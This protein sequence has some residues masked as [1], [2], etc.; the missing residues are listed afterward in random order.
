M[1]TRL[2]LEALE[3]RLSPA[4]ILPSWNPVAVAETPT[5]QT[6][7]LLSASDGE[8]RVLL[9]DPPAFLSAPPIQALYAQAISESVGPDGATHALLFDAP[10]GRVIVD[11]LDAAGNYVG[12]FVYRAPN[13]WVPVNIVAGSEDNA[14]RLLWSDTKGTAAIWTLD[15]TGTVARAT[16]AGPFAGWAP[17]KLVA[18]PA[19]QFLL[20]W[21]GPGL[22]VAYWQLNLQTNYVHSDVFGPGDGWAFQDAS[23]DS[24]G[25]AFILWNNSVTGQ[26]A[27]WELGSNGAPTAAA[28]W[29][30]DNSW[31]VLGVQG[32]WRAVGLAAGSDGAVRVLWEYVPS[33][34]D[35]DPYQLLAVWVTDEAGN[36]QSAQ[37]YGF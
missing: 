23:V 35:A 8:M 4:A 3:D 22:A 37:V 25:N 27:M 20:L 36:F 12:R 7:L 2:F 15:D 31:D 24:N 14:L 5:N 18:A 21:T 33:Q 28:V 6:Q 30:S 32:T 9:V 34:A 16:V 19:N 29:S 1:K 26:A 10:S 11:N 13:G 17:V